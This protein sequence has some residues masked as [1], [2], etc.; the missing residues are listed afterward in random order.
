MQYDLDVRNAKLNAIRD[1]V[2]PSPILRIWSGA[3]PAR[4][5]SADSGKVLASI[6]LPEPWLMEAIDGE[7][8]KSGLWR[9]WSANADGKPGHFRIYSQDGL[10][11]VQGSIQRDMTLSAD[12]LFAGQMFTVTQFRIRD[13]NG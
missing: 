7:I 13:N 10:C 3:L 4:C 12:L 6:D 11:R 2:G 9:D 5:S 8:E 1:A